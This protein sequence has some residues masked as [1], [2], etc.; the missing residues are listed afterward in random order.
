[1]KTIIVS[2]KKSTSKSQTVKCIKAEP[3]LNKA[4]PFKF[5]KGHLEAAEHLLGIATRSR[6]ISTKD[7]SPY[8]LFTECLGT[9]IVE[10]ILRKKN[11]QIRQRLYGQ[12]HTHI[13]ISGG[14]VVCVCSKGT[15]VPYCH[16]HYDCELACRMC[17]TKVTPDYYA[18][19]RIQGKIVGTTENKYKLFNHTSNNKAFLCGFIRSRNLERPCSQVTKK[20]GSKTYKCTVNDL[21]GGII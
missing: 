16:S 5:T 8:Q 7:V 13:R 6:T 19:V 4:V 20:N 2:R 11:I 9:V 15:T 18:F 14:T 3:I 10:D 12:M 17:G 1:M 21:S